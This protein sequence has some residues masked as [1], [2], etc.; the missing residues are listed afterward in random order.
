MENPPHDRDAQRR[1]LRRTLRALL[2]RAR[3]WLAA[4][5]AAFAVV[6][7]FVLAVALILVIIHRRRQGRGEDFAGL[8]V[9]QYG[10]GLSVAADHH[11][12]VGRAPVL[13]AKGDGRQR[14]GMGLKGGITCLA[15]R[16]RCGA[17][18][19]ELALVHGF[20]RC[21]ERQGPQERGGQ[22]EYGLAKH[23]IGSF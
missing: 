18:H 10:P 2:W 3:P 8:G 19:V 21:R 13:V 4:A 23:G 14:A 5:A 11:R 16:D 7:F 15:D 6:I 17:E 12:L 22:E 1:A 9:D 20:G